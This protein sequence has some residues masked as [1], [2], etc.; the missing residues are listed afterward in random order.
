MAA[1][2]CGKSAQV[3]LTLSAV[4]GVVTA[5]VAVTEPTAP[6]AKATAPPIGSLIYGHPKLRKPSGLR[7]DYELGLLTK[8]GSAATGDGDISYILWLQRLWLRG[9]EAERT[10]TVETNERWPSSTVWQRTAVVGHCASLDGGVSGAPALVTRWAVDAG[11]F[12]SCADAETCA[13][14]THRPG[15]RQHAR[16]TSPLLS[17]ARARRAASTRAAPPPLTRMRVRAGS[18]GKLARGAAAHVEM[19]YGVIPDTRRLA[20]TSSAITRRL[21]GARRLG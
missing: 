2:A 10:Q 5:R 4:G 9:D 18:R 21:G 11:A 19:G 20:D 1:W 17:V 3:R 7:G 15:A 16:T 8:R 14:S 6:L 12:F 13:R